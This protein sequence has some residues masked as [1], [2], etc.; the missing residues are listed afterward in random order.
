MTRFWGIIG[1]DRGPQERATEPG[2][3]DRVI[4]DIQVSGE[5]RQTRLTWQQASLG[6]GVRAQHVL[7][8]IAPDDSDINFTEVVYVEWQGRKWAVVSITY[9]RPRV[10]FTL[11]GLYNG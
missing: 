5:L 6:E 11:G 7:S 9:K 1:V 8:M 4:E 3:Y 2:I 10:E